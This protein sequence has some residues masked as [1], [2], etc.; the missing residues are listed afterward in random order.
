MGTY[1]LNSD[2]EY[3]GGAAVLSVESDAAWATPASNGLCLF[4]TATG[5]QA[6]GIDGIKAQRRPT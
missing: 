5:E 3:L 2:D 4:L 1:V 6:V